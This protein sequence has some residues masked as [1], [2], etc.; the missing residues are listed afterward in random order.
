M[1]SKILHIY[2][3]WFTFTLKSVRA[4]NRAQSDMRDFYTVILGTIRRYETGRWFTIKF[5]YLWSF[6]SRYAEIRSSHNLR[7]I[8][9]P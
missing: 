8:F 5:L 3:V 2:G 6:G 9:M 1:F 7:T 4:R